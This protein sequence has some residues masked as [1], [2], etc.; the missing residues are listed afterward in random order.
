M[1]I[2]I[3]VF[4]SPSKP[5]PQYYR[6]ILLAGSK[7]TKETWAGHPPNPPHMREAPECSIKIS[8]KIEKNRMIE[9]RKQRNNNNT[10]TQQQHQN[11]KITTTPQYKRNLGGTP[12]K[13]PA[14]A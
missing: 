2:K 14:H 6:S 8:R 3:Q 12:P 1:Q 7:I 5:N 9:K 10:T 4:Y 11:N 13:P